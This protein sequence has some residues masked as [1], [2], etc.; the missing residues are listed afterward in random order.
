MIL[1]AS[2]KH[3]KQLNKAPKVNMSAVDCHHLLWQSGHWNTGYKKRL[4]EHWYMKK[5][6][7]KNTLH[8]E[9]HS[10]I[11]DIIAPHDRLCEKA[12]RELTRMEREGLIH[13]EDTAEQRIDFLLSMWSIDE[14]PM[15]VL[16]LVYEQAIIR[17]FYTKG[18]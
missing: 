4:R 17:E 11:A 6:I 14:C 10:K 15:T 5:M 3:R 18:S 1:M 12:F 2:R 13:P 16:A 8:R 9:I 7:P